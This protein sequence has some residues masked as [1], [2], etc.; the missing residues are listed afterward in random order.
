MLW[1]AVK[2]QVR[3]PGCLPRD[4]AG[5][6]VFRGSFSVNINLLN[7]PAMRISAQLAALLQST[8]QNVTQAVSPQSKLVAAWHWT[9]GVL[10]TLYFLSSIGI[11]I[12]AW[13][14]LE[15]LT[16]AKELATAPRNWLTQSAGARQ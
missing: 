1:A 3:R 2:A 13:K 7:D 6:F 12:A 10:E 11:L 14:G 15:Q 9:H 5:P 16:L 4:S 8:V